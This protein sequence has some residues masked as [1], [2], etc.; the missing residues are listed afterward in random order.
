[1]NTLAYIIT[2]LTLAIIV[3]S[4][5]TP[6]R[7]LATYVITRPLIQPFIF[8]QLT[9]FGLPYSVIWAGIL[10]FMVLTSLILKRWVIFCARSWPL[11]VLL[12]LSVA[13]LP[14]SIDTATSINGI[15]R[16][17]SALLAFIAAYNIVKST[18][19]VD[20]IAR[21]I[22]FAAIIPL[23]FGFYQ[24]L[25]GNYSQI[26]TSVTD[27][28]NSVFGVGNA[29]GIFLTITMA[30]VIMALLKKGLNRKWFY[31]YLTILAAILVSQILALNRGTWVALTF[32]ILVAL[33]PYRRRVKLRWI[34]VPAFLIAIVFSGVI[35]ERFTTTHIRWDGTEAN[36]FLNRQ[37]M[38]TSM[39]P[40]ILEKPILGHGIGTTG[41]VGEFKAP[42]N[43][44]LRM[45]MDL[46]VMG[47]LIYAYFL[48]S[49]ATLFFFSRKST[50]EMQL[51]KYN[52]PMTVINIYIVI[53][54]ATQNVT[55]SFINFGF[56]LI[57]NGAVI[58][59]NRIQAMNNK[60]RGLLTK[61]ASGDRTTTPD[62]ARI[63][64]TT[65]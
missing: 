33:I 4:I 28:V 45:A 2:G 16:M 18:Q 43:D 47:G 6:R 23:L 53:I 57:L 19:D 61:R 17:V 21:A 64:S 50:G 1:M 34:V 32:G 20:A 60:P 63:G 31:F 44:Y 29:Y 59:L 8:L 52:F 55:H 11:W 9:F 58:K 41:E 7:I 39:I 35:I 38:W 37:S 3:F 22:A 14:G 40:M 36:T 42:H 13:S 49:L 46:G 10:P 51:W 62:T 24:E 48:V 15:I 5:T 27:R 65:I 25:T 30:P 12:A 54:S 56:F 26:H